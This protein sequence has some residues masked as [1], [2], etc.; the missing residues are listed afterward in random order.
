MPS[1]CPQCF[2][3]NFEQAA[4]C[5]QCGTQLP[6]RRKGTGSFTKLAR[7]AEIP[8]TPLPSMLSKSESEEEEEAL[9]LPVSDPMLTVSG[10]PGIVARKTVVPL[11]QPDPQPRSMPLKQVQKSQLRS[12]LAGHGT[13]MTHHSW[14]LTSQT[15]HH[16][17]ADRVYKLLEEE[18][19]HR[20]LADIHVTCMHGQSGQPAYIQL[21]RQAASVFLS[22]T[23]LAE[24]LYISRT[25]TLRL[26]VSVFRCLVFAALTL[27]VIIA[28]FSTL[29]FMSLFVQSSWLST[30][31][32]PSPS[33]NF[34]SNWLLTGLFG[35]LSLL[36]YIPA[37]CLFLVCLLRSALAWGRQRDP[38]ALLRSRHIQLS[39]RDNTALLEHLVNDIVRNTARHLGI[40]ASESLM[41]TASH[42]ASQRFH[43]V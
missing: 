21:Q 24:Y 30:L 39:Q 2:V 18:A 41:V 33:N 17:E 26:P 16:V 43:L 29:S 12:T 38:L 20:N 37:L 10:I 32:G 6:T 36:I 11:P 5:F 19:R 8:Q 22:L 3:A 4:T 7:F 14:F 31:V 28:P 23:S 40:D 42:Q 1:I 34:L 35:I 27:F 15:G 9:A 13:I 25:T